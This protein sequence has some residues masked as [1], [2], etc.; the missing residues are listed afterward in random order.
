MNILVGIVQLPLKLWLLHEE[1]DQVKAS[2]EGHDFENYK[3]LSI[4]KNT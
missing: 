2:W 1:E 3:L 4:G